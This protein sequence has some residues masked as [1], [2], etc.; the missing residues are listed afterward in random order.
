MIDVIASIQLRAGSLDA[1]LAEFH[2]LVPSVLDEDGCISYYPARDIDTGLASQ[3]LD[4]HRVTVVE[5]W[6]SLDALHAHLKAPHMLA[7]RE[8][9]KD[10]VESVTLRVVQKA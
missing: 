1:F 2:A 9:V 8:A 3:Q 4:P 5:K 10:Y 6:E 7:Y